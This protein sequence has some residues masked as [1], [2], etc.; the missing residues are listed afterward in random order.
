MLRTISVR[1]LRIGSIRIMSTGPIGTSFDGVIV[2]T[3]VEFTVISSSIISSRINCTRMIR[4]SD[5]SIVMIAHM[6]WAVS[7]S[8]CISI[9]VFTIR[10]HETSTVI[11]CWVSFTRTSWK[12]GICLTS[13]W[14]WWVNRSDRSSVTFRVCVIVVNSTIDW[15]FRITIIFRKS[16]INNR[17]SIAVWMRIV[18]WIGTI[19]NRWYNTTSNLIV[20]NSLP[21]N[22]IITEFA[23]WIN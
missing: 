23:T 3:H 7:L 21:E 11:T 16:T 6:S 22:R 5:N 20:F 15:T 9:I 13:T 8:I 19:N 10:S 2:V 18:C 17:W 1:G 4:T 14:C 12:C